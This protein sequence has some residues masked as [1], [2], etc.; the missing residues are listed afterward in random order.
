MMKDYSDKGLIGA[1][2]EIKNK[3]VYVSES[4]S[5]YEKWNVKF[6][7]EYSSSIRKVKSDR[8]DYIIDLFSL[9]D[10]LKQKIC[11]LSKGYRQRLA[12]AQ[13]MLHNP[14]YL[15]LDEPFSAL[16]P[17]QKKEM[18]SLIEKEKKDKCI[19]FSTHQISDIKNICDDII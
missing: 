19:I 18:Y 15:I 3:I 2:L 5:F 4:P 6:F 14:E 8:I 10:V 16:D 17:L 1:C 13:C 11:T 12:F 9:Q 7:L